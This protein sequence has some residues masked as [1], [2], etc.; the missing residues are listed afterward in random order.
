[1]NIQVEFDG[2]DDIEN[3]LGENELWDFTPRLKNV[4]GT[5]IET[6]L[7]I[8]SDPE[9]F[10]KYKMKAWQIEYPPR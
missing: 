2:G 7:T 4:N 5:V 3:Y 9:R 1:M 6:Y 10:R 8:T